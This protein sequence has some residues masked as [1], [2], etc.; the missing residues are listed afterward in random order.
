MKNSER[1]L[2]AFVAIEK[3]LQSRCGLDQWVPFSKLIEVASE[4]MPEVKKYIND[5]KEYGELRNAIVH[6]RRDNDYVIA[7][8][9]AAAV[10]DIEKI[11]DFI[12]KPPIIFP[13][14]ERSVLSHDMNASIGTAVKEMSERNYS[15]I[16]IMSTG[17]FKALLTTDTIS[18]WLGANVADD[19]VSLKET[20]IDD[21]LKFCENPNSFLFVARNT[22]LF[23]VLE[24]FDEFEKRG[25]RLEALLITASGN[26][27]EKIIGII[28][29]SDL[30]KLL[31][32]IK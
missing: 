11:R 10:E 30:P 6:N 3:Y 25:K 14:F 20:K 29:I 16:P 28:T 21:V 23:K 15:Q 2:N 27:N 26:Q 12:K 17:K 22:S 32:E 13:L 1:F 9:N 31:R 19:L 5:L 8:P 7:E 24:Y 4:T 18:R